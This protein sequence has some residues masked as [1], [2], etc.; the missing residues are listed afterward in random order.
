MEILNGKSAFWGPA[1]K[2]GLTGKLPEIVEDE[3]ERL[4]TSAAATEEAGEEH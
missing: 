1:G 2:R 3:K 4:Q